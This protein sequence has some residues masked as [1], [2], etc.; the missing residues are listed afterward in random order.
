LQC[1]VSCVPSHVQQGVRHATWQRGKQQNKTKH[2]NKEKNTAMPLR[3]AIKPTITLC[4]LHLPLRHFKY[5]LFLSYL[6]SSCL[7]VSLS[8]SRSFA[9]LQLLLVRL[10]GGC[11]L[12][13]CS[14]LQLASCFTTFT[15]GPQSIL[16]HHPPL[17]ATTS[18]AVRCCCAIVGVYLLYRLFFGGIGV[19]FSAIRCSSYTH[20]G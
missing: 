17:C 15:A 7:L 1:W 3:I 19:V 2:K 10:F 18:T 14:L 16:C 20:H 9:T 5:S 13:S 8:S 12:V 6:S 11:C 4:L